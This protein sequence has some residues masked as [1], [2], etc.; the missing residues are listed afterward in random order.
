[1]RVEV[2]LWRSCVFFW[3]IRVLNFVAWRLPTSMPWRTRVMAR[4]SLSLNR[5]WD[6]RCLERRAMVMPVVIRRMAPVRT[7]PPNFDIS[8]RRSGDFDWLKDLNVK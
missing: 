8:G 1:M 2:R 5:G 4:A 7:R 6:H 3:V